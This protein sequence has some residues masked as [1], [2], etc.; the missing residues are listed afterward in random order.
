MQPTFIGAGEFLRVL[1]KRPAAPRHAP[2][3]WAF[4][5]M[6]IPAL[7]ILSRAMVSPPLLLA[8]VPSRQAAFQRSA[9]P[10]VSGRRAGQLL[11]RRAGQ[12]LVAQ[13]NAP[14]RVGST[15]MASGQLATSALE[16]A[17]TWP[18]WAA[19]A[20][21]QPGL[22]VLV[23]GWLAVKGQLERQAAANVASARQAVSHTADIAVKLGLQ[24][25]GKPL[26]EEE[27]LLMV[28]ER[29][30]TS[31]LSIW[32]SITFIFFGSIGFGMVWAT[33]GPA[34]GSVLD[35]VDPRVVPVISA[36]GLWIV[37]YAAS[38]TVSKTAQAAFRLQATIS[39]E[40]PPSKRTAQLVR[41]GSAPHP[42][43]RAVP[44]V[45][46]FS[47]WRPQGWLGPEKPDRY[48]LQVCSPVISYTRAGRTAATRR[49]R[50]HDPSY[51]PPHSAS[52][53]DRLD[54]P[55]PCPTDARTETQ[56][57]RTGQTGRE[58]GV[59]R[60]FGFCA[61]LASYAQS[62]R[63][64]SS[65]PINSSSFVAPA[66]GPNSEE[67]QGSVQGSVHV[68]GTGVFVYITAPPTYTSFCPTSSD[69]KWISA[70]SQGHVGS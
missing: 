48:T 9:A 46:Q 7:L 64:S 25:W 18:N 69:T 67:L 68:Y 70:D 10:G 28:I 61:R 35:I 49:L 30:L 63:Q 12:L 56:K 24:A 40:V 60:V 23:L 6:M 29:D 17:A 8:V 57:C 19:V 42:R 45:A 13:N 39:T 5:T 26:S 53:R 58:T 32:L 31:S 14:A 47:I 52:Q 38:L 22:F 36:I 41:R 27:T 43:P 54:H 51:H 62:L 50:V 4:A 11:G 55:R 2:R 20:H 44:V 15:Q 1:R 59:L 3:R 65:F 21:V 33:V 37:S 16:N 34:M 66:L